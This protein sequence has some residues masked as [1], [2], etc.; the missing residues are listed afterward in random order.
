MKAYKFASADSL[1]E[2]EKWTEQWA[3][4]KKNYSLLVNGGFFFG[5][6]GVFSL[7]DDVTAQDLVVCKSLSEFGAMKNVISKALL[8]LGVSVVFEEDLSREVVTHYGQQQ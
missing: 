5:E 7:L 6:R 3:A 1:E 8:R 4:L 2:R